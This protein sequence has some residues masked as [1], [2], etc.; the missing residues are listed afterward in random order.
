LVDKRYPRRIGKPWRL[1]LADRS[2][3]FR[4]IRLAAPGTRVAKRIVNMTTTLITID[5]VDL[6]RATGGCQMS[7][8][9]MWGHMRSFPSADDSYGYHRPSASRKAR[10][11]RHAR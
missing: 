9:P 11:S 7:P 5:P 8:C 10:R 2:A 3:D 1:D 6:E 4:L